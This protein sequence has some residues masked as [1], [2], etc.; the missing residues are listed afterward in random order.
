MTAGGVVTQL[1]AVTTH[2]RAGCCRLKHDSLLWRI[3]HVWL[4]SRGASSH[5]LGIFTCGRLRPAGALA[6]DSAAKGS[7]GLDK[8]S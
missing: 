2:E 8:P 7:S 5:I 3:H 1:K 4:P 6:Q